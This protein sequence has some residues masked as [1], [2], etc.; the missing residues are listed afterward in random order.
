MDHSSIFLGICFQLKLD[1]FC[2]AYTVKLGY[3][4][5]VGS[6]GIALLYP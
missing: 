3:R 2:K 1:F 4:E 5:V 6:N